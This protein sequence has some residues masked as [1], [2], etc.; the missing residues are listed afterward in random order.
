MKTELL[1]L[2]YTI[3]Q[4][5]K[6]NKKEITKTYKLGFIFIC[7]TRLDSEIMNIQLVISSVPPWKLPKSVNLH[8]KLCKHLKQNR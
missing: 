7:S 3:N 1:T 5:K 8:K 6:K 4:K 2:L